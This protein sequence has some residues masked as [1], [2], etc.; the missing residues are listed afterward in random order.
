MIK[1]PNCRLVLWSHP[2]A[3]VEEGTPSANFLFMDESRPRCTCKLLLFF[4]TT[5]LVVSSYV[6]VSGFEQEC[7]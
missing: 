3:K 6:C 5:L 1:S 2:C 4:L 7:E